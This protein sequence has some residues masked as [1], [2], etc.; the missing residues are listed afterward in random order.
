MMQAFG[1][2]S[3]FYGS[4]GEWDAA[5]YEV[6]IFTLDKMLNYFNMLWQ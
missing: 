5:V 2:G 6:E 4:K 3:C 1:F